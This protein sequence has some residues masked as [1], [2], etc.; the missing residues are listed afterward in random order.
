M[1]DAV[2]CEPVRTAVGGFGG[3]LREVSAH[4]TA[5]TAIRAL[6][7][8]TGLPTAAVN[9]VVLGHCCPHRLPRG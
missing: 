4:S 5:S 3:S 1:R 6:L 2:I 8:R 9:D 7:E